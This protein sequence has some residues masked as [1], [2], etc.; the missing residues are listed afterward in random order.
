[1]NE[2]G[3]MG[4]AGLW[5]PFGLRS[6]PFFQDE[7][8]PADPE[9]PTKLFVGRAADVRRVQLGAASALADMSGE[10]IS[11]KVSSTNPSTRGWADGSDARSGATA[12]SM[13]AAEPV[14]PR[15]AAKLLQTTDVD[16]DARALL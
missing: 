5:E 13:H 4:I 8:T 1:M 3:K 12:S 6:S 15:S 11:S 2:R 7:L 9:H 14:T 16:R 10:P